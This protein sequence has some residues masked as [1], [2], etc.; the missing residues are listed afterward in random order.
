MLN[1]LHHYF[2]PALSPAMFNVATI[3][4]AFVL[5][6]LMPRLGWP[7]IMA[8]AHRRRSPAASARS[9][10]SGRR[11]GAKGSAIAPCSIRRDPG[12]RPRAAAD[13][14]RHDR[15]RARR[16]STS[17]STRCSRRARAPGAVSWL[18]YAFRL[19]YLPIGLF[20]VSIAHRGAAGRRR[21]TRRSTT[22]PGSGDT[23]RA[24]WRMMLM[25]NVPATFGLIV[26]AHADRAAAVRARPA[27]CRPTPRRHGR[28]AAF[29]AV[30]LVGYSAAR[31]AS[32]DLLRASATA[33][34]RSSVSGVRDCGQRRSRASRWSRDGFPRAGARHVDRVRSP[35]ARLLVWLLRPAARRHRRR[36]GSVGDA[37]QSHG[38]VSRD[39]RRALC[40]DSNTRWRASRRDGRCRRRHCGWPRRSAA[41]L[42][43]A[44]AGD[45]ENSARSTNSTR[46]PR[47][48]QVRVQKLLRRLANRK[49][50][51]PSPSGYSTIL[52]NPPCAATPSPYASSF[53]FG[54]GPISTAMKALI[55]ANVVMFLGQAFLPR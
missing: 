16:R 34:C 39:G 7:P 12:L 49:R 21:A 18:T 36:D 50:V 6:P 22:R 55:G 11:C 14:A 9:R 31:I 5:V 26:L 4:G 25:L 23:C 40:R 28:G 51:T 10:C 20:G 48:G 42:A 17:S 32:P 30:G 46:R 15:A 33:A 2:V 19:M 43:G 29:Y 45:R 24:G 41:A 35:T 54:P 44:G 47:A 53:S 3:V 37:R 38:V 1:S 8:I 52:R 13:G 27:S